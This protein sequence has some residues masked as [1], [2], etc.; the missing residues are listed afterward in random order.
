MARVVSNPSRFGEVF[1]QGLMSGL[2]A[3]LEEEKEARGIRDYLEGL[4]QMSSSSPDLLPIREQIDLVR[5]VENPQAQKGLMNFLMGQIQSSQQIARQNQLQQAKKPIIDE[6]VFKE[7]L[8]PDWMRYYGSLSVGGQTDFISKVND[9]IAA[10]VD[11]KEYLPKL[12]YKSPAQLEV[13]GAQTDIDGDESLKEQIQSRELL[14]EVTQDSLL[15]TKPEIEVEEETFSYK[16]PIENIEYKV[17]D[18]TFSLPIK[19]EIENIYENPDLIDLSY[20][21]IIDII[22]KREAQ[23]L[24]QMTRPERARFKREEAKRRASFA[25]KELETVRTKYQS[26]Q[27]KASNIEAMKAISD[28]L[29]SGVNKLF[30][31]NSE[32]D[33]RYIPGVLAEVFGGKKAKKTRA[34]AEDFVKL[35]NLWT[36]DAKNSF[37]SR[38]TNFDL[39]VF[40]K[41][42]PQLSNTAEGRRLILSQMEKINEM[43]RL[44]ERNLL[45]EARK[46]GSGKYDWNDLRDLAG[47]KSEKEAARLRREFA[48][49]PLTYDLDIEYLKKQLKKGEGLFINKD[50]EE[51]FRLPQDQFSIAR[52]EGLIEIGRK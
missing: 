35:V 32:G 7:I 33:V 47:K 39:D 5:K 52:E 13:K 15:T 23:N 14:D 1:G 48:L 27:E 38:I 18:Q 16:Q 19:E 28:K 4:Y 26:D 37:G 51:I 25:E 11:P 42:L 40:L 21:Q 20:D 10:G 36:R 41:Q 12:F 46:H 45:S 24:M 44:Y 31:V 17:A 6:E 49:T 34:Y 8:G 43:D 29:P 9:L 2:N 3:Y 50:T 22:N 30:Q